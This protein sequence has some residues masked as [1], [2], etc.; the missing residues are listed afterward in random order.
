MEKPWYEEAYSY[1]VP[2]F[3]EKMKN[4][5]DGIGNL[6]ERRR[7]IEIRMRDGVLYF[8]RD[9][10]AQETIEGMKILAEILKEIEDIDF[11]IRDLYTEFTIILEGKASEVVFGIKIRSHENSMGEISDSKKIIFAPWKS[12]VESKV[13]DGTVILTPEQLWMFQLAKKNFGANTADIDFLPKSL[14]TE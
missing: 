5:I 10:S 4:I 2:A 9:L 14:L 3:V 6:Y 13:A 11:K 1:E 8:N 7:L 12:L